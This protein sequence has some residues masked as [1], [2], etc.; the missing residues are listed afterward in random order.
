S[1]PSIVSD[2]SLRQGVVIAAAHIDRDFLIAAARGHTP[3]QTLGMPAS[4]LR[5]LIERVV[6]VATVAN[7]YARG[8]PVETAG[9]LLLVLSDADDRLAEAVLDGLSTGW[10]KDKPVKLTDE[11]EKAMARLFEHV[12]TVGKGQIVRLATMW[13]SRA[14]EKQAAEIGKTL[15]AT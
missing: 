5:R 6:A 11:T 7:H 13:G 4:E 3:K 12:S 15:L 10:P 8:A 14:F 9:A 1:D 2:L